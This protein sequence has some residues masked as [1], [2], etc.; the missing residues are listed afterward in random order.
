MKKNYKISIVLALFLSLAFF[1]SKAQCNAV[2]YSQTPSN[3]GCSFD[4]IS[5]V[6][7]STI[8]RSSTCDTYTMVSTPNPTLTQG[9]S[10]VLSI[11]TGGDNEG[12]RAWIDYNI[13]GTFTNSS[14]ELVLGPSF[15]GTNP[16]TYT[17]LVTIPFTSS[18]GATRLRTRCRY[19]GAPTDATSAENYGE[20]EDYCVT[21]IAGTSCTGTPTVAA[22]SMVG[23]TGCTGSSYNL[24]S[25]T[26][27]GAT[28]TY[29]WRFSNALAGTYTS[30]P[31]ATT[32]ALST[33]L[34]S[35]TFFQMV[36]TCGASSL[37][38]TSS[39][40]AYTLANPGPCVCTSYGASSPTNGGDEDIYL[41][42]FGSLN[43]V[44]TCTTV[45]SGVGSIANRYSNYTGVLTPADICRG[46]SAAYT[47]NVGSCSTN[48]YGV[49]T[50]VFID[51]N[52]N[53]LF[54]DPGEQ[55]MSSATFSTFISPVTSGSAIAVY[56]GN[57]A[58]PTTASLGITRMRVV[59]IEGS[60]I[61]LPVSSYGYGE[62][63]DYCIN[64]IGTS[65]IT[66]A[67]GSVCPG[68]PFVIT[69]S[70]ASSYTYSQ[71][72]TTVTTTGPSGTVNPITATNY[73]VS[74]TSANGCVASGSNAAVVSV[75]VLSSPSLSVTSTPTAYCVGGSAMLNVSGGTTYTWTNNSSNA[76]SFSV[77]PVI[78]TVY[79][80]TG[81]GST[82][83][84]GV[85]TLTVLVNQ[86]PTVT[87]NNGTICSGYNFTMNPSGGTSYTFTA[88]SGT[89]SNVVSPNTTANYSISASNAAG[90]VSG[91]PAVVNVSVN[92]S[93]TITAV[94]G[95]VCSGLTYSILP[96]GANTYSL[97]AVASTSVGTVTPAS[98]SS[99][100]VAG[101][102]TNGCVSPTTNVASINVSVVANPVV[103]AVA[104]ST[105]ICIGQATTVLTGGGANTYTWS[106][107]S[108]ASTSIAVSPTST[109]V[110][111]VTGTNTLSCSSTNTVSLL[112]N[113]LPVLS[114][115]P[116][117][118]FICV[119][120][121]ASILVNGANT[122]VWN[123]TSTLNTIN[124]NPIVTTTYTA[125]GTNTNGCTNTITAAV[126]VNTITITASSNTSICTGQSAPLTANGA[127]TYT[128][129]SVFAFQNI[130]VTPSVNTV[131]NVAATDVNGCFHTRSVS[132][133]LYALPNVSA[134]LP[135]TV[136][137]L[138]ETTT[139]T[140]N[141]ANTYQWNNG[142]AGSSIV[143]S[144][145]VNVVYTYS[146]V[147]T[148][149]NN[150]S[151][152]SIVNLRVSACTGIAQAQLDASGV[153][154]YPNP[155]SGEF[156]IEFAENAVKTIVVMDVTG[157][158]IL[159]NNNVTDATR[160]NLNS[161]ANG[162]YYVKVI[163]SNS[164]KVVKI[165]KD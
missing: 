78:T 129:N 101:T 85:T 59:T 20:T 17:A 40:L 42:R 41:V 158:I 124:V 62:T 161:F 6:S 4:Y 33:T 130:T 55:V 109:T 36:T 67:G 127:V 107:N 92:P 153:S 44:S 152:S 106:N 135:S 71:A 56:T 157:R 29:Q 27:T 34:A 104:A 134:S 1:K 76:T 26:N 96:T 95:T 57:I 150:C 52:Q 49:G 136:I 90:C 115:I 156:T 162:V 139:I 31:G 23:A 141:G 35:G 163:S 108:V 122:Y 14:P 45:A 64:I 50:A 112:V 99:Y 30:I 128:W 155:T 47:V 7:F 82:V 9:L 68:Q 165:V 116:A 58:V 22:V 159:S 81:T 126:N 118:T 25:T 69:P 70:G 119:G 123:T 143:V 138:G 149:T 121:N 53:G 133:N 132:I 125:V 98:T 10:Y 75:A 84:N 12:V 144:P 97:N 100:V 19:N 48:W 137:C 15:A 111:T 13:D 86:L 2:T 147:G 74:F 103:T 140:A 146:V 60:S 79:T 54:T 117:S 16:A 93:P 94:S 120:G 24:S 8:N 114:T 18:L 164:S 154:V 39:A 72:S 77:N 21:I 3:F 46:S 160:V 43:N 73:S 11:T 32:T 38:S 51:F 151:S 80:V 91:T 5:N 110:Y 105:A 83:C 102:G 113:P 148:N 65:P 145:T 37:S 28:V 63:E 89:V 66:A 61:P 87:V 131:Y 142:S 88:I